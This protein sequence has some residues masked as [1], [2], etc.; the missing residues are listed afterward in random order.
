LLFIIMHHLV[1][2]TI[3]GLTLYLILDKVSARIARRLSGSAARALARVSVAI[4]TAAVL[5]GAVALFI[6]VVRRGTANLSDLMNQM[7]EILGSVRLWLGEIVHQCIPEFMTDA[8][9]LKTT[10][11][12]WLKTHAQNMRAGG[13]W[14][15]VGLVHV[16]MG[17]LLS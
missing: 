8:E 12:A 9:N 14:I 3:T 1:G 5:T 11:A 2:A 7:A 4:I 16:V 6:A 15:G 17:V 10:V 13:L